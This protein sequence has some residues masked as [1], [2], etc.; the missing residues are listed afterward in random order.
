MNKY[1]FTVKLASAA[2]QSREVERYYNNAQQI[3]VALAGIRKQ[4]ALEKRAYKQEIAKALATAR[5][6]AARG[7]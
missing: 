2:L 5:T 1:A 7:W 4:A 3:A 6:R